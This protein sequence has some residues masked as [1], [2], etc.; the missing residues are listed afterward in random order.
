MVAVEKDGTAFRYGSCGSLAE[1]RHCGTVTTPQRLGKY[2]LRGELGR[3]GMGVVWR[4]YDPALEREVAIKQV[5]ERT[6]LDDVA[7]TRFLHEARALARLGSPHVVAIFD[8]AP[9]ADPPY[10]VMELVDGPSLL[11]VLRDRGPLAPVR[12]VDYAG[13]IL[14][15]L[16]AAHRAGVL[17][18]DIKPANILLAGQGLIKIADFGLATLAAGRSE[19]ERLTNANE[20]VGTVRYLAPEVARGENHGVASDL[21]ALG[22]S[23]VELA[24]GSHPYAS[25]KGLA[26]IQHLAHVP[27]PPIAELNLGVPLALAQWLDR[28][29]A[30]TPESRFR[31]AAAAL[32][33]LDQ[34]RQDPGLTAATVIGTP[35]TASA[36][37]RTTVRPTAT[38]AGFS[39]TTLVSETVRPA[40]TESRGTAAT[41]IAP[42][43]RRL[44][45]AVRLTIV[46]WLVSSAA[47]AAAGILIARHAIAIQ[48][49]KWREELASSA[50]AAALLLNHDDQIAAA[51][52]DVVAQ[53][54]I[55]AELRRF[56][57]SKPRV[58]YIYS[59]AR[60]TATARDGSLVFVVDASDEVDND[61]NGIIDPNERRAIFGDRYDTA[62]APRMR[63]AFSGATADDE[64]TDDQWGVTM[65]GYAPIR[66]PTDVS[67][68][69]TGKVTGDVAGIVGL[70]IA[71]SHLI[72]LRRG[73]WWYVGL[74]EIGILLG[75][76]AA[77][78]LIA[79]R[80]QRPIDRLVHG[81][82][83]AA[84]GDRRH[85]LAVGSS[86]E[87]AEVAQAFNGLQQRLD[88][89]ERLRESVERLVL[90]GFGTGSFTSGPS[91]LMV[92][93]LTACSD[94]A[95][96][97]AQV[98]HA[99]RP[100]GG[101]PEGVQ[102]QAVLI[103][104][105]DQGA[106]DQA[107]EL[108][109]RGALAVVAQIPQARL[110]VVPRSDGDAEPAE[111]QAHR[112]AQAGRL[113]GVDILASD[114][115]TLAVAR[116]FYADRLLVDGLGE[117][118]AIK[119]AVGAL[120]E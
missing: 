44:P 51:G 81:L 12:L 66:S 108:A 114:T 36:A 23:L 88:E 37:T 42:R 102:G 98:L 90:R 58:R 22:V 20:V 79:R 21:Y 116:H 16:D 17:H 30:F 48:V 82:R 41:V 77:A 85:R 54:K 43:S 34:L 25:M 50:S 100:F 62:R 13:Q 24:T 19:S 8:C 7:L 10:L 40:G 5:G 56:L 73:I 64:P 55:F 83:T 38:P 11:R 33:G 103:G 61:G 9:E 68:N 4:A 107:V 18:R 29:V 93:D 31:D 106:G 63:E 52:G 96:A 46:L 57:A 87:F 119:G 45:F 69:F 97:A 67:G 59:L 117:V 91:A 72:A 94:P 95:Q 111:A 14:S 99:V 89:H 32:R 70:D 105:A 86:D 104:W 76:F 71:E 74:L 92:C 75:F 3:G 53:E 80:F 113:V 28:L 112:L 101:L 26:L 39:G 109:L 49:G 60:D 84:E 47:A 1:G 2:L 120:A 15:G 27:L 115:C 78:W 110:G 6:R 118:F 65:S 35:S